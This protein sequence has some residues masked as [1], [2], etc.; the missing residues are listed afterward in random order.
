[1]IFILDITISK[2]FALPLLYIC[3]AKGIVQKI[4]GAQ[5]RIPCT[6][7]YNKAWEVGG[8]KGQC[9]ENLPL[10]SLILVENSFFLSFIIL[11]FLNS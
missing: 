4:S 3:T 1:M 7:Q 9:Q 6:K 11:T 10:V 8:L 2:A 5:H